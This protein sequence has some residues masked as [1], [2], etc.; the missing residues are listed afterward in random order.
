MPRAIRGVLITCEPAIK[1]ILLHIDKTQLNNEAIIEDLDDTHLFVKEQMLK[2]LQSK[3]DEK[4]KET[5]R[6]EQ[7]LEDS[8]AEGN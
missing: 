4:L 3:L 8:D 6:V 7:P 5:Y 2:T 1:S